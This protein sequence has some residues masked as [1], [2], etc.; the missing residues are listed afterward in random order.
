MFEHLLDYS[1]ILVTGPQRSGTR[2]AA[3]MIAKDTKHRYVD[4]KEFGVHSAGGFKL[5]MDHES[6]ISVHC[7]GMCHIIHKYSAEDTMIVMM[8]RSVEDIIASQDRVGWDNG[9]L[10]ELMKYGVKYE[11]LRWHAKNGKP[12]AQMKYDVWEDEQQPKIIHSLEIEYEWLSGH[13]LWIPKEERKNFTVE[14][15]K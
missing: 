9:V 3:K 11:H 10:D 6:N 1:K 4:E 13:P 15:T 14:Q 7:P 12:I 2:I 5:I 8:R